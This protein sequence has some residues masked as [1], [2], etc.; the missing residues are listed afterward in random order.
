M[1]RLQNESFPE[2]DIPSWN[3]I[4]PTIGQ[5][6]FQ[7]SLSSNLFN[8]TA[9]GTIGTK[10]V[11]SSLVTTSIP[12]TKG[13]QPITYYTRLAKDSNPF[14]TISYFGS[15]SGGNT[16]STPSIASESNNL[17]Q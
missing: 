6:G 13:K 3:T 10:P 17:S 16:T 2:N 9:I 14:S 12:I 8:N 11:T 7:E 5:G 15:Q 4:S 1:L